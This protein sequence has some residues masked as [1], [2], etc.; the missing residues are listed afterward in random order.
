MVAPEDFN[1]LR[2]FKAAVRTGPERAATQARPQL[3]NWKARKAL[4]GHELFNRHTP[5]PSE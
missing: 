5:D 3:F 4:C 2:F 1:Q